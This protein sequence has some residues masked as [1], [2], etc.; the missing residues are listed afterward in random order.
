MV[1]EAKMTH[2]CS[3]QENK[4]VCSMAIRNAEAHKASEAKLLQKEHGNILQDLEGQVIWEEVRSQADFF[5]ACQA[6]YVC[7]PNGTPEYH[8]NFL[9]H[10]IRA[11]TSITPFCP[12]AK[13]FPQWRNSQLQ[14]PL[15]HQC[16]NGALS[17]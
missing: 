7:Q 4:A 5:F 13:D 6:H 14:L 16:P 2:A 9:P 1:K 8:G 10:S 11:D 17:P 15:P 12:I 3:I